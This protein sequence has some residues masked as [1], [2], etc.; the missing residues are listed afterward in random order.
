ML[1]GTKYFAGETRI[2]D[3]TRRLKERQDV[4]GSPLAE[5]KS[6]LDMARQKGR[7]FSE[8]PR[9]EEVAEADNSLR[10]FSENHPKV[11]SV[12][13]AHTCNFLFFLSFS[14]WHIK[15]TGSAFAITS[16]LQCFHNQQT[17]LEWEEELRQQGEWISLLCT[18]KMQNRSPDI[19]C[20]PTP[21]NG[22]SSISNFFSLHLSHFLCFTASDFSG[23][24]VWPF[25][26]CTCALWYAI[27]HLFFVILSASPV[28][29]VTC[30][31]DAIGHRNEFSPISVSEGF[32]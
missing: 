25:L 28:F 19:F 18:Q 16:P 32:V 11:S 10:I 7:R 30:V 3:V 20:Y 17:Q 12:Y 15:S 5:Q 26:F 2:E 24:C 23:T 1:A 31:A 13:Y 8:P 9:P 22:Q 21:F 6:N 27:L 29:Y 4:P 14:F